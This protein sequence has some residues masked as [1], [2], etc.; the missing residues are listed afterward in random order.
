MKL[1]KDLLANVNRQDLLLIGEEYQNAVRFILD[2]VNCLSF[3]QHPFP[4]LIMYNS[5]VQLFFFKFSH[6]LPAE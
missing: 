6:D 3:D 4:V 1:L 2:F 5:F